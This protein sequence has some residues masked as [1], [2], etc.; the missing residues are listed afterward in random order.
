M[1]PT[2]ANGKPR[3]DVIDPFL[4][5][6]CQRH[7][8]EEPIA[9]FVWWSIKE[10]MAYWFKNEQKPVDFDYFTIQPMPYRVNWKEILFGLHQKCVKQFHKP[11]NE[12]LSDPDI[13]ALA[14]DLAH[15]DLMAVI[16]PGFM[17]W[18]LE[19]QTHHPMDDELADG[20]RTRYRSSKELW[21]YTKYYEGC[22]RR[23][24][25]DT[26]SAY[27][28]WL[29][30][31][32]IPMGAMLTC[33]NSSHSVPVPRYGHKSVPDKR[34][35]SALYRNRE[36]SDGKLKKFGQKLKSDRAREKLSSKAK[37]MSKMSNI[38]VTANDMRGLSYPANM[39]R[40]ANNG[41]GDGGVRVLSS[42]QGETNTSRLLAEGKGV[43]S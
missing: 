42:I 27:A 9:M 8:I 11:K 26:L 22:V 10:S 21:H 5:F 33:G 31:I 24:M 30:K 32:K 4:K 43:E 38:S 7:K 3:A 17:L 23:R 20:E 1:R 37:K 35:R 39:D 16:P 18:S 13:L 6:V 36:S 28:A 40:P 29:E 12:W 34:G 15:P 25:Q 41:N 14:K 2:Y 19:I